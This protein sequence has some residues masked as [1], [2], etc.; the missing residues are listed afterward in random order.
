MLHA[1][2]G[3]PL[4]LLGALAACLGTGLD[5][6]ASV[7]GSEVRLARKLPGGCVADIGTV[8]IEVDALDEVW[9]LF[10]LPQTRV[11]TRRTCLRAVKRCLD[12]I[13]Q[14]FVGDGWRGVGL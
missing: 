9:D 14:C 2:L 6:N 1:H 3:V 13:N 10:A 12:R 4:A 11:G 8:E 7:A 5:E